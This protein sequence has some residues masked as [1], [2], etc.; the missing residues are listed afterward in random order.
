MVKIVSGDI[1]ESEMQTLVNPVNCVGIMGK[2]MALQFK[3]RFPEMFNDYEQRCRKQQVRLGQPYLYEGD[4][5]SR[6]I[7]VFPTKG[8]WRSVS[9]LEDIINGLRYL[10]KH[11]KKWGIESLAVPALGCGYGQLD[12]RLVSFVLQKHLEKLDIPVELYAPQNAIDN[13]PQTASHG[14]NEAEVAFS[15]NASA[16]KIN[17]AWIALVDILNRIL[18]QGPSQPTN[19]SFLG[20][21]AYFATQKGIPTGL[22]FTLEKFGLDSPGLKWCKS[23]LINHAI[24]C[25]EKKGGVN[26]IRVG[27]VYTDAR[28]VYNED[29]RPWSQIVFN[30]ARFLRNMPRN[31]AEKTATI[32]FTAEVIHR[33]HNKVPTQ[34]EIIREL[35]KTTELEKWVANRED[36]FI[37]LRKLREYGWLDLRPS[38]NGRINHGE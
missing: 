10:R 32:H 15:P 38:K 8:H 22:E 37:T 11:Y 18:R 33:S 19:E 34:Q 23:V 7:L 14:P 21:I 9:R 1:F 35:K 27:P 29:I 3:K 26:T 12:W 4:L 25:Q 5:F 28:K 17:P 16:G 20:I 2:G 30:V 6:P 31:Q 24:L 13:E 36:I